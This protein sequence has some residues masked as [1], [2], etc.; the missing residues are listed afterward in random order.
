MSRM[1]VNQYHHVIRES[2]VLNIGVSIP[3]S[4]MDRLLQHPVYLVE[5]EITEDGRNRSPYTKGNFQFE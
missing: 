3:A 5:I 2:R 1:G 4:G